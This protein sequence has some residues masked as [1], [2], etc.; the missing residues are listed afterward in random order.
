VAAPTLTI[1]KPP[2]ALEVGVVVVDSC[3]RR[4]VA[5]SWVS[6]VAAFVQQHSRVLHQN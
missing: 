3:G 1:S 4:V 6:A 5:D 2:I